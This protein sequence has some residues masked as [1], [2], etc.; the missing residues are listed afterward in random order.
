[1][2]SNGKEGDLERCPG[3]YFD[4]EAVAAAI[5]NYGCALSDKLSYAAEQ[6]NEEIPLGV[7]QME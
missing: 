6:Y 4:I 2:N 1:M 7:S 3:P 5:E